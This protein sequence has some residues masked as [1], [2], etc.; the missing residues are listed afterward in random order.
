[1]RAW[2]TLPPPCLSALRS[3]ELNLSWCWGLC[4]AF[5]HICASKVAVT[6]SAGLYCRAGEAVL[7]RC[8]W[9]AQRWVPVV[10]LVHLREHGRSS[11]AAISAVFTIPV[12]GGS[13]IGSR[14]CLCHTRIPMAFGTT[15]TEVRAGSPGSAVP[16]VCKGS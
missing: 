13:S 15:P 11:P 3:L 10:P 8:T 2:K 12:H 7:C 14:A 1:M 9:G 6:A 16:D 4:L 5:F